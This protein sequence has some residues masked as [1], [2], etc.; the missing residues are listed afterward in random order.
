[1][2]SPPLF[3]I[4][5]N[6]L[7]H[8]AKIIAQEVSRPSHDAAHAPNIFLRLSVTGGGCSGFQYNFTLDNRQLPHDFCLE[9]DGVSL[10]IDDMS[11][12]FLKGGEL[13][14]IEDLSGS[15]FKVKNPNATS[16]CGCGTS[17]AV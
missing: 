15:Y 10:V 6:A 2:S 11:L 7:R 17:F 5:S 3:Q 9:Q 12:P 13:D 4:T 16:N 1:M 8:V 14:Y